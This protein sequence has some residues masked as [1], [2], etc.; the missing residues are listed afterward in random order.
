MKRHP[1]VNDLLGEITEFLDE[2]KINPTQFGLKS[3]KD[4]DFLRAIKSGSR[5]P[6]LPTIDRVRDFMEKY[7]RKASK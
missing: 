7:P 5:I 4:G 3:V 2:H 1:V 6:S